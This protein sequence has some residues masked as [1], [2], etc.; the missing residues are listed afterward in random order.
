MP[1]F[2][3]VGEKELA[4]I[5]EGICAST[6]IGPEL[7]IRLIATIKSAWAELCKESRGHYALRLAKVEAELDDAQH[8]LDRAMR[9]LRHFEDVLGESGCDI[10]AD[11]RALLAGKPMVLPR[12]R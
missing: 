5:E 8:N 9:V 2:G 10:C 1:E 4:L 11:G 3:L 6:A 7:A 12:G